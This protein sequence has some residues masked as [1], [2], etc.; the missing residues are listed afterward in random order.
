MGAHDSAALVFARPTLV[1]CGVQPV[2][3]HIGLDFDGVILSD[4]RL[5]WRAIPTAVDAMTEGTYGVPDPDHLYPGKLDYHVV[6]V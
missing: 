4:M 5:P 1:N 6:A 3:Y 2:P